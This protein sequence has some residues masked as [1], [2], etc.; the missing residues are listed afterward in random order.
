MHEVRDEV[1]E[2]IH[3]LADLDKGIGAFVVDPLDRRV[4]RAPLSGQSLHAY[5]DADL[6][7][8]QPDLTAHAVVV[9]LESNARV[10]MMLGV[11]AGGGGASAWAVESADRLLH[12]P[13]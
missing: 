2:S 1:T 6:L 3:R 10:E 13:P 12:A 8:E 11:G 5:I 4:V 9:G 7:V